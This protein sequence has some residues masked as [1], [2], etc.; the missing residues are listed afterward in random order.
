MPK[1]WLW[2]PAD[3]AL[4]LLVT[5][6][7]LSTLATVVLSEHGLEAVL[8]LVVTVCSRTLH[9]TLAHGEDLARL[10]FLLPLGLGVVMAMAEAIR[11]L[12][13]THRRMTLLL[14]ARR[15]L[16]NRLRRLLRRSNW[17]G[18]TILVDAS[19]PLVFTQGLLK[20]K[21][22]LSTGLMRMLSDGEL[23]AVLRHEAHHVS[24]RDPLKILIVRCLAR[25]LFLLPAAR[26][27]CEAYCVAKEIAA[28]EY[29]SRT[30][31][32]AVPLARAIRKLL[33]VPPVPMP[34]I[35]FM[36]SIGAMEARLLALLDASR[37]L[38]LFRLNRLGLSLLGLLILLAV[39][40]A[41]AAGH[42]P[43]ISECTVGYALGGRLL[44][45]L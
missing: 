26:D 12:V 30:M 18:L 45:A 37:P 17:A 39:A 31:G 10:S 36:S 3:Q 24:S 25:A 33:A 20:P 22:C 1:R 15:P 11:L 29:V 27:I 43:S 42:L 7:V 16:T 13:S 38:P 19:R 44:L 5:F 9:E 8:A 28:D 6:A 4:A 35:A 40:F 32:D 41:P 23:E 34:G 14:Q 21:V 2:R